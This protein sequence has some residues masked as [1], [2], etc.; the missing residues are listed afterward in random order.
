VTQ[1]RDI[2]PEN[3]LLDDKLDVHL[4]EFGLCLRYDSKTAVTDSGS[5]L[6]YSS[7]EVLRQLPF[8]GPESDIWSTYCRYEV[9]DGVV[10][11]SAVFC[12]CARCENVREREVIRANCNI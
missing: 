6:A 4:G 10:R 1:H 8:I 9:W 2:K 12:E 7:P 5:S 3:I 11:R